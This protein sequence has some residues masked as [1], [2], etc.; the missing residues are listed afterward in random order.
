MFSYNQYM[1]GIDTDFFRDI[2]LRYGKTYTFRKQEFL[3][4][5]TVFPYVGYIE[6][7]IFKYSCTDTDNNLHTI[8]FAFA[9]EFVGDYPNCLYGRKPE[10]SIQA[11]TSCRVTL[12]PAEML[13]ATFDQSAKNQLRARIATEQLFQQIYNRYMELF[14]LSPEERYRQLLQ[15]HPEIIRLIPLKEIAS[16][17]HITPVHMSRI[18]KKLLR[19]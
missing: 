14:R 15:K 12:C 11:L 4:H 8:G 16:Y 17:L 9:G 5:E 1:S 18:R 7:G 3:L 19:E 10:I 13:K 2:C 6:E